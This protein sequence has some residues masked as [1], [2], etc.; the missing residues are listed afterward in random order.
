MTGYPGIG[1]TPNDGSAGLIKRESVLLGRSVAAAQNPVGTGT[2]LQV[3]FGPALNTASDPVSLAADGSLTVH[4]A[5]T[6]YFIM[7]L[8]IG[9][10]GAAG[11]S[12]VYGRLLVNGV[13]AGSSVFS[14]IGNSNQIFTQQFI[15]VE[16][17]PAGAVLTTEILR[18]IGGN[19]SGGLVSHSPSAAGW[20]DSTTA[21]VDVYRLVQA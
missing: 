18:D 8:A 12:H 5:G 15:I 1:D 20:N 10:E 17:F 3:E 16:D 7:T 6:Y 4:T 21:A 2:A 14:E 11:T 9:R 19:N 13:Q